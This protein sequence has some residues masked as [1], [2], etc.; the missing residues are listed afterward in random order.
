MF[1]C[2]AEG[3]GL[4]LETVWLGDTLIDGE[5][6]GRGGNEKG[7]RGKAGGGE[8]RDGGKVH[9][10]RYLQKWKGESGQLVGVEM[11]TVKCWHW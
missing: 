1:Y 6:E 8:G 5:G 4:A 11:N 2:T 7:K 3:L 9:S 10:K